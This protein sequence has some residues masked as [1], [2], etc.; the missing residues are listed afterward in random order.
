MTLVE[1][2]F[3]AQL[4]H[5][6][7]NQ[8]IPGWETEWVTRPENEN[9]AFVLA[10][11]SS[12]AD[13]V[14][15]LAREIVPALPADLL[16][17]SPGGITPRPE[18][19]AATLSRCRKEGWHLIETHSHPFDEGPTTTFSSLDWAVDRR[20]MPPVARLLPHTQLHVTMVMGRRSLDAHYYDHA[21]GA[22]NPASRVEVLGVDGKDWKPRRLIPTT[23]PES[24]DGHGEVASQYHRQER[25]LGRAG[26]QILG[27]TTV[28]IIGLGGLG[29]FAAIQ[30][31]HLGIGKLLLIDPDR[32][33]VTNLNRLQGA[34]VE[35]VGRTKVD[36]FAELVRRISPLTQVSPVSMSILE[37][38][39]QSAAKGADLL[40][41]A[42]T[43]MV[44][45][46]Y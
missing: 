5:Q 6:L 7:R 24:P 33:E 23:S 29:S 46:S 4:W 44:L 22:I 35:D 3:P 28:A 8:Q 2:V 39:A 9:F 36:V 17:Q 19:V 21:T 15:L 45:D 31:A 25:L 42:L 13:R 11:A 38:E 37:D 30:L 32:V 1:I 18:F 12:T 40:L 34:T 43:L 16:R 10:G 27:R 26:Q 41:D 14:R 20:K